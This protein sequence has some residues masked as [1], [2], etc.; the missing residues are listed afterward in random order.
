MVF[1]NTGLR[2]SQMNFSTAGGSEPVQP[3]AL[4]EE[5]TVSSV[6]FVCWGLGI[7]TAPL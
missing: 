5:I 4:G 1:L 7:W 6:I 2:K 3:G